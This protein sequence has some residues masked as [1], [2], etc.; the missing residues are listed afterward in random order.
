MKKLTN[1]F[2]LMM[3]LLSSLRAEDWDLWQESIIIN[4]PETRYNN[5]ELDNFSSVNSNISI[6]FS[7]QDHQTGTAV[8][9]PLQTGLNSGGWVDNN[10][11]T[12]DHDFSVVDSTITLIDRYEQDYLQES[13]HITL[14]LG[15]GNFDLSQFDLDIISDHYIID[16]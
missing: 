14:Q 9:S 10:M 8:W 3:V 2:V 15:D 7:A 16:K 6:N 1:V 5:V 4:S 12:V 13:W 11:I